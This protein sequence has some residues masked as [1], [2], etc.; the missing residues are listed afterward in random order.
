MAEPQNT[1]EGKSKFQTWLAG[2]IVVASL[3]TIVA[4]GLAVILINKDEATNVFN[5]IIPVVSTWVG[6]VLAYYFSKENFDAATKSVTELARLTTQE[7]L[8]S[9]PVKEKMIPL[10]LMHFEVISPAHPA[11]QVTLI[12]IVDHQEKAKKGLR[13]PILDDNRFPLYVIHRS[14]IDRY[15]TKRS[16]KGDD[17]TKIVLKELL[18]E[19][20]FKDDLKESFEVVSYDATLAD[21]K[22]ALDKSAYTQDVFVSQNGS[23]KEAILGFITN[24]MVEKYSTVS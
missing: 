7:K 13:I 4:L 6:T 21:V 15:L 22:S 16:L 8:Q 18:D 20:E 14:T 3:V 19:P 24:T 5:I 2:I 12:E 9:I 23:D 17:V 10:A 11:D 1:T